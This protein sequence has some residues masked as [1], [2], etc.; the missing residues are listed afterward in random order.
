MANHVSTIGGFAAGARCGLALGDITFTKHAGS[1][2]SV[3]RARVES[4][5]KLTET[6]AQRRS[7]IG[8]KPTE[9]MRNMEVKIGRKLTEQLRNEKAKIDARL[10]ENEAAR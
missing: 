6:V 2:E 3:V 9:H 10:A 4:D 7:K 5:A 1:C 8:S